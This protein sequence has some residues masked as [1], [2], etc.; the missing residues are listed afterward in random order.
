MIKHRKILVDALP[1]DHGHSG[2]SVYAMSVARALCEIGYD[3]TVLVT[4]EDRACF[5]E[6]RVAVVPKW[7]SRA[8]GSIFYHMLVLPGLLRRGGYD[9]CL[10]AAANRRFPVSC[11]IPVIGTVHDLAQY[12]VH[13]KYDAL[14][15]FY[16]NHM[17]GR[18]VSR[19][20]SGVVAISHS[21]RR[22]IEECWMIPGERIAVIY[23]GLALPTRERPG[24]LERHGLKSGQYILYVSRIEHPGKNHIRLIQAYEKLPSRLSEQYEL[25]LVGA[26]WK[27]SEA[28]FDYARK[29]SL[30]CRIHFTGFVDAENLPEAYR[31]A[32]LYVFPSCYEGFGLSIIEAMHYGCPCCCSDNSSLGEIGKGAALLFPH[33][34]VDAMANA[35]A[36][37]LED[38]GGIRRELVAKGHERASRFDWKLHAK[39]IVDFYERIA[40]SGGQPHGR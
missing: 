14:R 29:S 27:D 18:W 8:I 2:I 7:A 11:P 3:V 33:E 37:V 5:N 13:G 25:V 39:G 15:R 36:T 4:A 34:N 9:F 32:A 10:V 1:F 35:M 38:R 31:S 22:D 30:G 24:F 12:R 20:A 23:N 16:L 26:P 28:V 40:A 21:T 19:G 6:C 17:L